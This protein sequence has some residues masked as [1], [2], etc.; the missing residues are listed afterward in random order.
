MYFN[1]FKVGADQIGEPAWAVQDPI[2]S[3]RTH[4]LGHKDRPLAE[5]GVAPG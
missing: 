2:R 3:A 5:V 1:R 4:V